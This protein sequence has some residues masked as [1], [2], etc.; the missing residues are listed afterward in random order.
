MRM[1][2]ISTSTK[3]PNASEEGAGENAPDWLVLKTICN[4]QSSLFDVQFVDFKFV[5]YSL[6]E[7]PNRLLALQQTAHEWARLV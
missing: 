3:M 5:E 2:I 6:P 4:P 1:S 7:T